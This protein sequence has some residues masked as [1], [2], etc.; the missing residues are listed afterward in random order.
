MVAGV[1]RRSCLLMGAMERAG[2]EASPEDVRAAFET[3][4]EVIRELG[5]RYPREFEVQRVVATAL[6][7]S[8]TAADNLRLDSRPLREEALARARA[9]HTLARCLALR[10]ASDWCRRTLRRV[11]REYQVPRCSGPAIRSGIAFH[12]AWAA[13]GGEKPSLVWRGDPLR[14]DPDP[15]LR[16]QDLAEIELHPDRV[17]FRLHPA[18]Q[19]SLARATKQ[20]AGSEGWL[21][22]RL[23]GEV[24]FAA[25]VMESLRAINIDRRHLVPM[26]PGRLCARV[27]RPLLPAGLPLHLLSEPPGL[28]AGPRRIPAP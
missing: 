21:V 6:V 7:V 26:A 18:A 28:P 23:E 4:L 1:I 27:E 12:Q 17:I 25:R 20:L 2:P 11:A 16:A 8:I 14:V 19:E 3:T 15:I 10:P 5:R 22:L 24:L 13:K 9:L